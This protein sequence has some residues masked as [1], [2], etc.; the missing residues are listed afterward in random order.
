MRQGRAD[1]SGRESWKT[2][3]KPQV[4][5][6]EGVAQEGLAVQFRKTPV[7]GGQGFKPPGPRPAAEGPGGGR[8]IYRSGSQAHHK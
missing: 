1:K 6:P 3:P 5:H 4:A 2:E 7:I 8:T